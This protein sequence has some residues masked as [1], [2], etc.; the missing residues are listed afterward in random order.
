LQLIQKEADLEAFQT[1][2]AWK[3]KESK[4]KYLERLSLEGFDNEEELEA[5]IKKTQLQLKRARNKD[6]GIDE[7]AEKVRYDAAR[8]SLAD[9]LA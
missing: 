4:A 1:I 3:S 2:Q 5:L 8:V 6:L 7:E 9:F